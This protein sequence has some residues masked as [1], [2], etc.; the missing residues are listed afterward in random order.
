MGRRADDAI[1]AGAVGE[2]RERTTGL[3]EEANR[4]LV[5]VRITPRARRNELTFADG[6]LHVR[7]TAPPV[8]GAANAT[9]IA[10]LAE[11]LGLPRRAI[12][13]LRGTAA[14]HKTVALDGLSADGFQRKIGG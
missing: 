4:L 6:V 1:G 7:L 11:R 9:L 13:I 14:R 12:H 3:R 10:L 8:E 5:T 2:A